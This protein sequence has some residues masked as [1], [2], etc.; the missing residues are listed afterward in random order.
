MKD[1][2][3]AKSDCEQEKKNVLNLLTSGGFYHPE[4]N[5]PKEI[6][7]AYS[8]VMCSAIQVFHGIVML[9]ARFP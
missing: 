4:I 5:I 3:L 7:S 9:I 8:S 2:Q 6:S 1:Q